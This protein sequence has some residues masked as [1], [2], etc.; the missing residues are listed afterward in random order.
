MKNN[1]SKLFLTLLLIGA[2]SGCSSPAEKAEK[3]YQKGMELI[4]KN[5][6]KAKLE[7][8][9]ALQLKKN[10]TK[11]IYSLGLIAEAK[12]DL[13]GTFGLMNE[14]V[15]QDPNNID[16]LVKTGQILLAAGKLDIALERSN[17][18]L[19]I[20]KKN[21][22]A[23]NLRSAL[24]L[25]LNDSKSAVEYA[26]QALAL[27]PSN[28]DSYV[29]LASERLLVKDNERAI[30]FLDKA[31]A[32]NEKN[33]AVQFIRIKVLENLSQS[34]EVDQAFQNV[35]KLFPDKTIV[36]KSYAQFLLKLDKKNEAEQQL[37]LITKQVPN[38]LQAKLDV[39]RFVIAIKG[40]DAGRAELESYVKKEPENYDLSFALV[41]LYQLQNNTVLEDKLLQ[42]IAAKAGNTV[43]G[44][45]AQSFIA[46]KLIRAGKKS[47]ASKILNTILAADKS[48]GQALTLRASL[49]L[50]A[51]DYDA[52]II[53][54]R[55]VLRDSPEANG[56]ALMLASA[57]E[58]SGSPE[59]AEEHYLRAFESSKFSSTYGIPYT[60]FLM[61]RKQTERAGKVYEQLLD[62]NPNDVNV[63]R[64]FAQYKILKGDYVGAQE[65]SD[66]AKKMNEKNP[67]ADQILGAISSSK[68]DFDAT[69][70][71]FK[72]AH[73]SAPS[74]SQPIAALVGT[75]VRAGK[76]KEALAFIK[77]VI[78]ENPS[79]VEAKIIQGQ[80]FA[81]V[82]KTQDAQQ[83]FAEVIQSQPKNTIGYQQ[84]A[85]AQ[86]RASQHAD[87]EKTIL[88]GLNVAPKDFGLKLTQ[89]SLYETNGRYDEAMK[90]YEDIIKDRPDSEIVANNLASL[91]TD[92]RSDK[93]SFSRAYNLV[94]KLKDSEIPQFLDTFGWASYR[95]GKL[96][97]AEKALKIATEKLPEVAVFHYHLG[98]VYIEKNDS[99]KAKQ[100]L[101]NA[102]K[103]SQNQQFS[104]KDEANELL[105]SL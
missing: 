90:V 97:E 16:A 18:A 63:I 89:A 68:N 87:A 61:R 48:Y 14:V 75:Y 74:D 93:A 35:I 44:Y 102:I 91:L 84:L 99:I 73:A 23:L 3:Y 56:A 33:L 77:S 98:K 57:H 47:E 53:D 94:V 30:E 83:V 96:D 70:S 10:M 34:K 1:L 20:D 45:K 28:Q 60:Q 39:I 13:K 26:N 15:E 54:L 43:D 76:N 104:Q 9:N 101:Q 17:K 65:L 11:A 81:T 19:A 25:K 29:L 50:E 2:I 71:A 58:S 22:S 100:A 78:D 40:A 51:K 67:L 31:L 4:E 36:R 7:F 62:S 72:R 55:T 21:V 92:H 32:K 27:D 86:Q 46:Y 85:I 24:Q 41:N 8:Q 49:A 38:D 66:K 95:V 64:T 79:N 52:A 69:I 5:P 42:E 103:Y 59:L 12:G 37:R 80:L 82:G 105:K 88:Q 6:D